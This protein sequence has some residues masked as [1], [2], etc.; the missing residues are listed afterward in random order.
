MLETLYYE[1]SHQIKHSSIQKLFIASVIIRI[2]LL[3]YGHIHDT[4]FTL[5]YTDID[6]VVFSDAAMHVCNGASPYKRETYRYTPLLAW[7]LVPNCYFPLFGKILFS[8]LDVFAGFVIYCI[9][10]GRT[11]GE[12]SRRLATCFWLFNPLNIIVCTRGN[13]ESV[14]CIL[15]LLTLGCLKSG[16]VKCAA[17][18][19]GLAVHFKVYPIVYALPLYLYCGT[20]DE[21]KNKSV[22]QLWLNR[23]GIEFGII[24]GSVFI[25]LAA[26][27]YSM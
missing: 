1:A 26:A 15:V 7:V 13:A 27:F 21:K 11:H 10:N 17:I 8:L 23:K 25:L 6:Y 24:S 5:K 4:L 22:F 20:M 9:V 3:T 18:L 2:L 12:Y 16:W 14:V 19:Y